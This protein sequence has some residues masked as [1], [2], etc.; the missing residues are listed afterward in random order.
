MYAILSCNVKLAKGVHRWAHAI[1]APVSEEQAAQHDEQL[2]HVPATVHWQYKLL[3]DTSPLS[4]WRTLVKA[5]PPEESLAGLLVH[6]RKAGKQLS[7]YAIHALSHPDTEQQ[8]ATVA[9]SFIF[10]DTP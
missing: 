1:I 2:A 6:M 10:G 8:T 3:D 4:P 7:P 5:H 9:G